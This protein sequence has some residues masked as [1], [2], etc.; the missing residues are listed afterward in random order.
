VLLAGNGRWENVS[1]LR[2]G[3]RE[4]SRRIYQVGL[5]EGAEPDRM[6]TLCERESTSLR[7]SRALASCEPRVALDVVPGFPT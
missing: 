7:L 3:P 2:E 5:I 6:G 1:S 4:I